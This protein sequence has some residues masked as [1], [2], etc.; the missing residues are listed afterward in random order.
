L[1]AK[2]E[3]T[4]AI[5]REKSKSLKEFCNLTSVTNPWN[6][7]YKMPVGKTKTPHK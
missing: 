3:Y 6:A 5:R 7:I 1:A 4:A 2:A